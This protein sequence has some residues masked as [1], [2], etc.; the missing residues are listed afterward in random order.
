MIRLVEPVLAMR[1]GEID[2]V[3]AG[4]HKSCSAAVRQHAALGDGIGLDRCRGGEM[5]ISASCHR[6]SA[7]SRLPKPRTPSVGRGSDS[8]TMRSTSRPR[9][10]TGAV[11]SLGDPVRGI[12]TFEKREQNAGQ[13]CPRRRRRVVVRQN[14]PR[15]HRFAP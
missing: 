6:P 12:D 7:A 11:R 3:H 9:P 15:V 8:P 10:A 5:N 13:P 14:D 1:S 2:V 4:P